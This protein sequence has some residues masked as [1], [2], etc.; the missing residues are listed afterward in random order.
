LK[1]YETRDLKQVDRME[2]Q[3]ATET[4]DSQRRPAGWQDISA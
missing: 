1:I 3:Y 4:S 2:E